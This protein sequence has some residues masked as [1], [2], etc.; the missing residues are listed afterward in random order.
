MAKIGEFKILKVCEEMKSLAKSADY[1][2]N[3]EVIITLELDIIKW[4]MPNSSKKLLTISRFISLQDF[5]CSFI[6]HL[7]IIE[8]QFLYFSAIMHEICK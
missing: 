6:I 5:I 4:E 2:I 8:L 3:L 1:Q 7:Y